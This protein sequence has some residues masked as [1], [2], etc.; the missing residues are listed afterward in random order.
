MNLH[1]GGQTDK[2]L[3]TCG[4]DELALLEPCLGEQEGR[5]VRSVHQHAWQ[6]PGLCAVTHAGFGK[7]RGNIARYDPDTLLLFL[8]SLPLLFRT[9]HQVCSRPFFHSTLMGSCD[10]SIIDHSIIRVC[11]ENLK[12]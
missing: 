9:D 7:T 4:P 3:P 2:E 6:Q 10:M 12:N 11:C 1:T 5:L 8:Y